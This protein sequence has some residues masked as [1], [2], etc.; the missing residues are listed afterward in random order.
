MSRRKRPKT[1]TE[2]Q[3]QKLPRKADRYTLP[4]PVQPNL[5]LRVPAIRGPISYTVVARRKK[6]FEGG[7][8]IWRT[9]GNSG[10]MSLDEARALARDVIRRIRLGLPLEDKPQD[11]FA[12]VAKEWLHLVVK[13]EGHRTGKESE[14]VIRKYLA[15][16]LDGRVFTSI[17]RSDLTRVLDIVAEANGIAQA[18]HTLKLFAAIANWHAA[19]DDGYQSPVTRGM[20]RGKAVKRDRILTDDEI[21]AIWHVADTEGAAGAFLQF[22]L[23][24]GQRSAK[25]ADLTWNDLDGAIW[26]VRRARREKNT[27]NSIKLPPLALAIA[28]QQPRIAGNHC[29]FG[30]IRNHA[31]ARIRRLSGT[32]GWTVHDCRRTCRSLLSRADVP[33]EVGEHVLGHAVAGV[34]GVYDRHHFTDE[35]GTAL[36]KLAALVERILD[37]PADNVVTLGA[38]S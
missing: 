18:N 28:H 21:R 36:E 24:C 35:I 1:L 4:D 27:P 31:V 16:H 15:P 23:L 5:I 38:V 33:G 12:T 17:G 25:I 34:R 37:P 10:F 2:R 13:K 19:R 6:P 14:R 11:S 29:I 20:R 7:K 30:P 32:S 22:A 8:Q 3:V 9:V 26:N